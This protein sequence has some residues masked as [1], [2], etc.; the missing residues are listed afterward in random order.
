M[1]KSKPQP[2]SAVVS[3]VLARAKQQRGEIEAI[4]RRWR[5]L[6][7]PKMAAHTK[8]VS[9]RRGRLIVHAEGPGESFTLSYQRTRLLLQLRRMTKGKVEEIV[10]RPGAR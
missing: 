10:I 1:G 2:I 9:L 8:P 6:V 7:G 5:A 4:R 3:A